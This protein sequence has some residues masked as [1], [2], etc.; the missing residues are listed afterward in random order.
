MEQ[1]DA[2][3]R[4]KSWTL[5]DIS[6]TSLP[7]SPLITTLHSNAECLLDT[8]TAAMENHWVQIKLEYSVVEPTI[9]R[10]P[11]AEKLDDSG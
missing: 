5:A 1:L 11:P 9:V 6:S 2:V 10:S 4:P 8:G 7:S 3:H